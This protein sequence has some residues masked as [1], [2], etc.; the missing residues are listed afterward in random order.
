MKK[1]LLVILGLIVLAGVAFTALVFFPGEMSE[2]MKEVRTAVI[3]T[4]VK[5][6]EEFA[7]KLDKDTLAKVEEGMRGEGA[8]II[9][10][11]MYDTFDQ[12][13]VMVDR[14]IAEY[15]KRGVKAEKVTDA[16]DFAGENNYLMQVSDVDGSDLNLSCISNEKQKK[17]V[18][19][20]FRLR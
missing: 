6:P 13:K 20:Q 10:S 17:T 9:Q 8:E 2:P 18:Y 1:V 19:V 7:K 3:Q 4:A 12:C 16:N 11:H 14:V 15:K 5:G